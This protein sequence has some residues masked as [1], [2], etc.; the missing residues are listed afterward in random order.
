MKAL[1]IKAK[2]FDFDNFVSNIWDFLEGIGGEPETIIFGVKDQG[3]GDKI[4]YFSS[5]VD[6]EDEPSNPDKADLTPIKAYVNDILENLKTGHCT[7]GLPFTGSLLD[8]EEGELA[9]ADGET[10]K[11]PKKNR[12]ALGCPTPSDGAV[13]SI[14]VRWSH[15]EFIFSSGLQCQG[16]DD[17]IEPWDEWQTIDKPMKAF[18]ES[19]KMAA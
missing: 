11:I 6:D 2:N 10:Y 4:S 17:T 3:R 9:C 18:V 16:A 12:R 19:F 13:Y 8:I 7:V 1:K 5:F 14:L 15:D